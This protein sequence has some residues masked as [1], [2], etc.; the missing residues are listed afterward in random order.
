MD[1][2]SAAN[3]TQVASFII[4]IT[5]F[6]VGL[7]LR[8]WL[9]RE[10]KAMGVRIEER[11]QPIQRDANGGR[12]LPDVAKKLESI[13]GKIDELHGRITDVASE[14]SHLKG[15]FDEH[16]TKHGW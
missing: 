4:P 12:S 16:S 3:W 11:T 5:F 13:D 14:V 1:I 10:L 8:H 7:L 6:L 9:Q 15:R 2:S